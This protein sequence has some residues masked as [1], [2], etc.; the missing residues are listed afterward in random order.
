MS[1]QAP[2]PASKPIAI[3]KRIIFIGSSIILAQWKRPVGGLVPN[4]ADSEAERS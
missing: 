3:P 4:A 1:E 2:S